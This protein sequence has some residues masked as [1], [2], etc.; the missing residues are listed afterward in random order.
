MKYNSYEMQDKDIV[1]VLDVRGLSNNVYEDWAERKL[2]INIDCVDDKLSLLISTTILGSEIGITIIRG[3]N[4]LMLNKDQ[5]FDEKGSMTEIG[6]NLLAEMLIPLKELAKMK[7]VSSVKALKGGK[8]T[9]IYNKD[10][11]VTM[12][13][14]FGMKRQLSLIS[15][16]EIQACVEQIQK[17]NMSTTAEEYDIFINDF[18]NIVR[19]LGESSIDVKKHRDRHFSRNIHGFVGKGSACIGN[20]K[21]GR[22]KTKCLTSNLYDRGA[23]VISCGYGYQMI[24]PKEFDDAFQDAI[25]D[26][27]MAVKDKLEDCIN[28]KLKE[29]RYYSYDNY[30]RLLSNLNEKY[31]VTKNVLERIVWLERKDNPD[32]NIVKTYYSDKFYGR[33]R[34]AIYGTARLEGMNDRDVYKLAVEICFLNRKGNY[35]NSKDINSHVPDV[36]KALSIMDRIF[37]D[38]AVY[39]YNGGHL[40]VPLT[41]TDK[42][43][44]FADGN[45]YMLEDGA[46]DDFEL[47]V[48]ENFT[49]EVTVVDGKLV[50]SY[51]PYDQI[52]DEYVAIPVCSFFNPATKRLSDDRLAC[53]N[54][55]KALNSSKA[56]KVKSSRM[57]VMTKDNKIAVVTSTIAPNKSG[58]LAYTNIF[59]NLSLEKV[60]LMAKDET[61]V[62][63]ENK[64]R[65]ITFM[66]YT[67]LARV[68]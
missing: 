53:A 66:Y 51:N 36:N 15:E 3:S 10:N 14:R 11:Q 26:I 33:I 30:N 4:V 13:N 64:E 7:K 65:Y 57:A 19:A 56:I 27:K 38:I 6:L 46:T 52:S 34:D 60:E 63:I 39:E 25:G 24:L 28:E 1:K 29:T 68:R 62:P 23:N 35:Y 31:P 54:N 67:L 49:G 58:K 42:P 47:C 45:V 37:G 50:A 2:A 59:D 8:I 5:I 9:T 43:K 12:T 32:K 48:E 41:V 44:D 55:I 17:F 61:D 21:S 16:A 20:I 40:E 18:V 22:D